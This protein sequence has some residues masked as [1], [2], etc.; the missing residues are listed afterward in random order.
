MGK[1]GESIVIPK[2]LTKITKKLDKLETEELRKWAKAY[3][4][5]GDSE[6]PRDKLLIKL[7][8]FLFIYETIYLYILYLCCNLFR[9]HT[10][11]V[12]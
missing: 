1:G 11:L 4:I 2:N 7:V 12:F 10:Q 9:V 5:D 6:L 8:C 3:G